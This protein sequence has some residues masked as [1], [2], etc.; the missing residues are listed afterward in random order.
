MLE[1]DAQRKRAAMW[2]PRSRR[3]TSTDHA[4]H[5]P[6]RVSIG[7][8]SKM[9]GNTKVKF[10]VRERSQLQTNTL[11]TGPEIEC[12]K[13]RKKSEENNGQQ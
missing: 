3:A 6:F 11:A 8:I 9:R 5:I 7:V 1:W 12:A 10:D 13:K 4:A 2:A